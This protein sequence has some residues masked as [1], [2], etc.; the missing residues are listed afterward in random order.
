M[1]IADGKDLRLGLCFQTEQSFLNSIQQYVH[2]FKSPIIIKNGMFFASYLLCSRPWYHLSQILMGAVSILPVHFTTFPCLVQICLHANICWNLLL[3]HIGSI[4]ITVTIATSVTS[5]CKLLIFYLFLSMLAENLQL[6]FK[7]V[8][9][10]K[11]P[12]F[13]CWTWLKNRLN[14]SK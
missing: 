12:H 2:V 6:W 3:I 8:K 1:T 9:C 7:V 5:N 13:C 11:N 4:T 14:Q 10:E